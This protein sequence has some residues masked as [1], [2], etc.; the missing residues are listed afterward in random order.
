M[1]FR[2][3]YYEFTQSLMPHTVLNYGRLLVYRL[4]RDEEAFIENLKKTWLSLQLEE[5]Q[6]RNDLPDFSIDITY[7]NVEHTVIIITIPQAAEPLEASYIGITYDKD[8]RF[9]Y[10]TYEIGKGINGEAIYFL[11]ERTKDGE[12]INYGAYEN[13]DKAVF[14]KELSDLLVYELF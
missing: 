6:C 1:G 3:D 4:L 7:P 13:V 14:I 5:P 9:R 12:H 11:C 8:D 2:E 10:F